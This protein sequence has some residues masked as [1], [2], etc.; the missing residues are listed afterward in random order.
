MCYYI[1]QVIIG[2]PNA[3]AGRACGRLSL[4]QPWATQRRSF[5]RHRAGSGLPLIPARM[6]GTTRRDRHKGM[7]M[8]EFQEVAREPMRAYQVQIRDEYLERLYQFDAGSVEQELY[9]RVERGLIVVVTDSPQTIFDQLG[10]AV[11]SVTYLGPT[12][13]LPAQPVYANHSA[14][15][16]LSQAPE[17]D[18]EGFA[19][20]LWADTKSSLVRARALA[21]KAA[22]FAFL[23]FSHIASSIAKKALPTRIRQA[24]RPGEEN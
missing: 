17:S 6:W 5:Y 16:R 13:A 20:R 21:V 14:V 10:G 22:L 3:T 2:A 23:P 8:F 12:A 15:S 24:P 9:A 18:I 19:E 1:A 4:G 7:G 11:K